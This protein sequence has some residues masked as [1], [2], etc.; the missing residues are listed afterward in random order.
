[1]ADAA[2]SLTDLVSD[3]VTLVTVRVARRPPD[4][5]YKFGYGRYESLGAL[6]VA[7]CTALHCP[8]LYISMCFCHTAPA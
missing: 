8:S 7:V 1:M 6:A 4:Q 5:R 2:H 3:F